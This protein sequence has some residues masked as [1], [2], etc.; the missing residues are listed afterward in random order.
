MNTKKSHFK[1]YLLFLL[2]FLL[3]SCDLPEELTSKVKQQLKK[4]AKETVAVYVDQVVEQIEDLYPNTENT[5]TDAIPDFTDTIQEASIIR[6]VDGDTLVCIINGAEYRVRLIGIDTPES[7]HPE[8]EKNT[9]L[10]TISSQYTKDTLTGWEKV[11]LQ[12][13]Q[14]PEDSY[15]RLL[16][17]VWMTK[18]KESVGVNLE[19]MLNYKL[20]LD[21]YALPME[22]KPNLS[23]KEE[24]KEAV[25]EAKKNHR[26]LWAEESF[27]LLHAGEGN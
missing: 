4:E 23:Y 25:E 26:G 19:N 17:Y 11:Y 5:Q 1:Y 2:S 21:G 14:D 22:I 16:A 10:G 24:I 15:E 9:Q 3:V 7:V 27:R 20:A 18:D 12:F 8:E 6:V 13:D